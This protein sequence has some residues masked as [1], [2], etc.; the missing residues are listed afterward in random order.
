VTPD[1][2]GASAGGYEPLCGG[3]LTF[4][5]LEVSIREGG[6]RVTSVAASVPEVRAWA[7]TAP[8]PARERILGRLSHLRA[9]RPPIVGLDFARPRVMGVLNV[10][11]DSFSDG[12]L[13]GERD[14]AIAHARALIEAGADIID[15]GG[16]STRPGAEP[17][18]AEEELARVLPVFR[19]LG[20]ASAPASIDTRRAT[21]MAAALGAGAS[22]INDVSAL[23]HDPG[24]LAVAAASGAPVVLMHSL[25]DPTTMQDAPAYDD[26]LLDIFDYLEAR[27]A[28]C[29][30]AGIEPARLVVDPGIGFGKTLAHNLEILRGLAVFHGLGCALMLGVSR[31]SF[32]AR[33][34]DGAPADRRLGGSLAAAAWGI[35][36]GVHIVRVHDVAET[37]QAVRILGAI[38]GQAK[39]SPPK[40]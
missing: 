9:P 22:I 37:V 33:A 35:A 38:V 29:A 5:D 10:T 15:V 6:A 25:G 4:R 13:F 12:G 32:I 2:A 40:N 7:E 31:K 21:V 19:A 16:E 27:I 20:D 1:E 39:E 34:S 8:G 18:A 23:T 14:A 36:R 3:P 26:V 17:V 11:P 24:S 30:E 28:A